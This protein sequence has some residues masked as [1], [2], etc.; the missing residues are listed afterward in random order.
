MEL[1]VRLEQNQ[2]LAPRMEQSVRILQMDSVQLGEYLKELA[3]ENPVAEVEPPPQ[4]EQK[5]K[6][7]QRKLEWLENQTRREQE[8]NGIL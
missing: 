2:I 4:R 3:L 8:N 5:E 1:G 7:A 6:L